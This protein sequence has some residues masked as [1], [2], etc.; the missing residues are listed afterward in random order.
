MNKLKVVLDTNVLLVSI[1][2]KS[3]YHWI[4]KKLIKGVFEL[5]ITSEILMEY[6]EVIERK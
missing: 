4:F 5:G 6:E 2:S 3:P 1:S